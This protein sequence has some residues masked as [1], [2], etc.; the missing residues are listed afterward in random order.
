LFIFKLEQVKRK[1]RE[2]EMTQS[3]IDLEA[4]QT[5]EAIVKTKSTALCDKPN[6]VAGVGKG[7][8]DK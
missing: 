8:K 7:L 2:D 4:Q 3:E 6:K 1:A 5:A